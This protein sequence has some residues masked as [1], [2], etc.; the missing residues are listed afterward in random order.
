[1]ETSNPSL[2][3]LGE[4]ISNHAAGLE[5]LLREEGLPP[6]SFAAHGLSDFP[7]PSHHEIQGTLQQVH[8]S[9]SPEPYHHDKIQQI[10]LSLIEASKA[11]LDLAMGPSDSL[12]LM[13]LIV[14]LR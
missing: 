13:A 7:H 11:M 6:L 5:E 8:L 9:D 1:M 4:C 2:K 3:Q 14:R 10:R 12:K